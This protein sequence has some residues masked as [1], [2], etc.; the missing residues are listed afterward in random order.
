MVMGTFDY[1]NTEYYN[2]NT[3]IC[4]KTKA[5]LSKKVDIEFKIVSKII[6]IKTLFCDNYK[7]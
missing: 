2:V 3:K 7:E 6:S 1:K 4:N 5:N